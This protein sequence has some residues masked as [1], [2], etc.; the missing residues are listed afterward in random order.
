MKKKILYVVLAIIFIV[1][2]ILTAVVGLKVDLNYAEGNTITFTVGKN[3]TTEEIS[4]IAKEVFGNDEFLVQEVEMFGDSALIKVRKD[5][6][7]GQLSNLCTKLNEKYEI[8]LE[9]SDLDVNHIPNNKLRNVIQ[10]YI[11]PM[12]LSTLLIVA[13]YAIR[14]KGTKKMLNLIKYLIIAEGLLYSLYAICRV[15]VNE[16]TMPLAV[17]VYTLVVI[18]YS[19]VNE[20]SLNTKQ[21]KN[22]QNKPE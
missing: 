5:I 9:T 17:T 15:P 12:G 20:L 10:P 11:I 2:L 16:L 3:I 19:A 6:T 22:E 14:F 4:N 18:I 13:F 21:A 1:A 7:E 8:E